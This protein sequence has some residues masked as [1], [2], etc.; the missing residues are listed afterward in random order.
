MSG[1]NTSL[2]HQE[3]ETSTRK[4][5]SKNR[6]VRAEGGF[7]RPPHS[8]FG[9]GTNVVMGF[10]LPSSMFKLEFHGVLWLARSQPELRWPARNQ[11]SLLLVV[12]LH[13]QC[14]SNGNIG[15]FEVWQPKT[16]AINIIL[17]G[18]TLNFEL[19]TAK[20]NTVA[21]KPEVVLTFFR[22]VMSTPFQRL[23]W[24]LW[25]LWFC[26]S[27]A[28]DLSVVGNA[29]FQRG[30][31][32]LEVFSTFTMNAALT[33][34]QMHCSFFRDPQTQNLCGWCFCCG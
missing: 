9:M 25:V 8:I 16:S 4:T 23:C 28:N 2:Y 24:G 10:S 6:N 11:K 17:S 20:F 27:V 12:I 1:S 30:W 34:S 29:L 15:I 22:N 7:R 19:G 18:T 3:T 14:H 26:G 31:Y 13:H 32:Q 33:L 5:Q 21:A